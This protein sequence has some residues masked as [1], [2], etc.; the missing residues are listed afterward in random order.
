MAKKSC[1]RQTCRRNGIG[2]EGTLEDRIGIEEILEDRIGIEEML[3][4]RIGI[5]E[6]LE[7]RI[8]I[9]QTRSGLES[10]LKTEWWGN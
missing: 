10:N 4:D 6:M 3:E 8:G 1:C 2:I 9:E 5:E 7:D